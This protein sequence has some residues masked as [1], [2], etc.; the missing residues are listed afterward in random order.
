MED[1]NRLRIIQV[2]DGLFNTR[3]YRSVTI[4]DLADRLGMSKKT[5]YLYFESKEEIAAA[6]VQSTMQ[7]IAEKIEQI[8]TD[9]NPLAVLR[10]TVEQIK[11][12]VVRLRPIFLEDIQKLLPDLW[13]QI[14]EFRAEKI[15]VFLEQ[16]I[17]KAQRDGLAKP[18]NS[19]LATLIFLE[20]I[21]SLVKPDSL[22]KYG[23]TIGEVVD[24][25]VE[26]FVGG[27]AVPGALDK[28]QG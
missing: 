10:D 28:T 11:G 25:L 2:A 27:I 9:S 21:Q 5:V 8:D 4:S 15:V 23:F 6:V 20:A 18:M 22:S 26:L 14:V 24:T 16:F 7:R 12:E 17:Q 1:S 3:G 19:R 13:Q